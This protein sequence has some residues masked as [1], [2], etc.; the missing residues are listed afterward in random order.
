M[1]ARAGIRGTGTLQW[2][3]L[4]VLVEKSLIAACTVHRLCVF[5][6]EY[7]LNMLWSI[8][9]E[10]HVVWKIKKCSVYVKL[11]VKKFENCL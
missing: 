8:L 3:P 9:M 4:Q 2:C 1:A 10:L 6:V 5:I 11:F 7:T